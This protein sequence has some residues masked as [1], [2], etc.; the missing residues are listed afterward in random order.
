MSDE[1]QATAEQPWGRVFSMLGKGYLRL[2]RTKLAHLDID[3]HYYALV[4]IESFN[5]RISQQEL[6]LLLGMDK[7]S[8]VRVV[9]YLSEKGYIV[10]KKS[11]EDKRKFNL[12]LTRKAISALPEIKQAIK[13]L[14]EL[15]I[16]GLNNS[17]KTGLIE[18]VAKLRSNL[19]DNL[20]NI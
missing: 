16:N 9:H 2:L 11:E 19:N 4:L 12:C 10:R 1:R 17:Q 7:V 18:T 5:N 13:E 6:S 8:V 20:T 3:R 15:S 14:N